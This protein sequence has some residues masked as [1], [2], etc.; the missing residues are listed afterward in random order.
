MQRFDFRSGSN[1]GDMNGETP[2][3]L[4]AR[5]ERL[6]LLVVGADAHAREAM[7]RRFSHM[8]YD[9]ILAE[10]GAAALEALSAW[11]FDIVLVD[12]Q[13]ADPDGVETLR[14]LRVSGLLR[15][16]PVLAIAP[17]GED[18]LARLALETGADDHV[19]KPFDFDV[20]DLRLRHM[21]RRARRLEQMARHNEVL[22]ARI[23]RRAMEL[24]ETRAE[25]EELRADRGRLISSIQALN[26]EIAR[27]SGQP[28]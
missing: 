27:L 18:G 14:R 28:S 5:A 19:A 12:M 2:M 25:L 10:S 26:E 4:D 3:A 16:A 15:G 13:P 8:R 7:A 1:V 9:V 24:G 20:A 6:H 22:D 17:E 23:A 11:H 21:V